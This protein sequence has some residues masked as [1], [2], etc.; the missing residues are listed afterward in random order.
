M[1]LDGGLNMFI[2]YGKR[3]IMIKIVYWGGAMS[4]KTTSVKYIFQKYNFQRALKSIETTSGRTLFFDFGELIINRGQWKFQ[5][6]LW[7]ATGQDFYCETRPTVLSGVDGIVFIID[8][9]KKLI[10]DNLRSLNEL[11]KLLGP[12][13]DDLP[14]IFCLNKIDLNEVISIKDLKEYINFH[15]NFRFF[16]T[17]A[18]SGYN[19]IDAFEIMIKEI[20]NAAKK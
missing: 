17:I 16:E 14:L 5:I 3:T 20:F 9:Q 1:G 13:I 6:N 4:G 7:T 8:G 11:K 18:T 12:K 10:A 19:V 15:G 2:D